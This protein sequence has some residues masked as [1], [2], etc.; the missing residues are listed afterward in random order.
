MAITIYLFFK[1]TAILKARI[2][3]TSD[4]ASQGNGIDVLE[5]QASM[6]SFNYF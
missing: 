5:R 3:D 1:D 4:D 2:E 6:G